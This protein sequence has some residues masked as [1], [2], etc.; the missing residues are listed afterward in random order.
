MAFLMVAAEQTPSLL[1]VTLL[2][3]ALLSAITLLAMAAFLMVSTEQ[4]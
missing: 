1:V 3:V 4:A 2:M